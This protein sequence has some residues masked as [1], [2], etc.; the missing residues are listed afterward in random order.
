MTDLTRLI[1]SAGPEGVTVDALWTAAYAELERL[2]HGRL[3]STG[4]HTLL[5]TTALVSDTYLRLSRQGR[6]PVA[7]RGEFFAYCARAM[8]SVIVDMA[9]ARSAE[10]RHGAGELLTLNTAIG[11]S[12]S[13][14]EPAVAV[15]DALLELEAV[16]PRLARVVEM[17]YF[18]GLSEAE[19]GEALGLTE[20]TVRRDWEKAR[21]LLRVMLGG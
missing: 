19:I 11:E 18:G 5:D 9:R 8:R 12:V 4:P 13:Q 7:S 17:R 20:R 14:P 2:A 15:H 10:K 16:E 3:R 21:R 6:L 1:E